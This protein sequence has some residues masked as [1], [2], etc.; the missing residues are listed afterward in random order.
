MSIRRIR[1]ASAARLGIRAA[2]LAAVPALAAAGLLAAGTTAAYAAPSCGVSAIVANIN[3]FATQAGNAN[4]QLGSLSFS[5]GPGQVQS[6]ALSLASQLNEMANGLSADASDL[7]GCSALSAADAQTAA[8]AFSNAAD[9]TGALLATIIQKRDIF[10]QFGVMPPILNALRQF[11]GAADSY[12][13][14]LAGVA[15]AQSSR[16]IGIQDGVDV[17]LGNA[18]SRYS[19]ICIPSP[20]YPTLKPICVSL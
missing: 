12:S 20:L 19:E 14:A 5:S 1:P 18:I 4:Q 8:D 17:S 9:A 15:P 10:A 16:I 6:A 11:E 13:S 3:A 2:A 7:G